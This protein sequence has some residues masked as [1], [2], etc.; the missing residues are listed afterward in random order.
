MGEIW[1]SG[2]TIAAGYWKNPRREARRFSAPVSRVTM[3]RGICAPA[4]W[5]FLWRDELVVTGRLKDVIIIRGVNYYPQDFE[6][7]AFRSHPALR[8][9]CCAAFS[10]ARHRSAPR[11]G[12]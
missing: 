5:G 9:D 1:A 3:P 11:N 4:I 2:P 10:S 8:P 6:R 12:S 7:A